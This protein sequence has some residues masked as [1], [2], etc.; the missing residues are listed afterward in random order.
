MQGEDPVRNRRVQHISSTA[1]RA[2]S[3][4]PICGPQSNQDGRTTVPHSSR[5]AEMFSIADLQLGDP[6]CHRHRD[7]WESRSHNRQ[8]RTDQ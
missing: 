4:S 7:E 3:G 1:S 6:A 2:A 8:T 5:S